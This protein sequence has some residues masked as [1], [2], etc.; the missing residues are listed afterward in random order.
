MKVL[1]PPGSE[2]DRRTLTEDKNAWAGVPVG[3][4]KR[5]PPPE[6]LGAPP[7]PGTITGDRSLPS[8]TSVDER[9]VELAHVV[10]Q[11]NW[12]PA[13]LIAKAELLQARPQNHR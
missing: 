12:L 2:R 9:G 8:S 10:T 6:R 1:L 11:Y 4:A 5:S 3:I 13:R 7:R